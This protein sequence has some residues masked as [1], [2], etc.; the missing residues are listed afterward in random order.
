[1]SMWVGGTEKNI[2]E[3]F[4]QVEADGAILLIDEI[5]G[6]LQDRREARHSWEITGVNEMLTQIESFPGI[7]IASTNLR[8]NLD[9]AALRRFDMKI[10][11][12]Y[13][14]PHQS[15]ALLESYCD[16]L[17][18]EPPDTA[19][20]ARLGR[21]HNLTPGDFAAVTRRHRFKPVGTATDMVC[22]L[23]EECSLK[24]NFKRPIGFC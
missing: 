18:L 19:L 21:L 1:M 2:A 6:F 5:E 16:T 20:T 10:K 4:R 24:E 7:F 11:F 17:N 23:E 12:D 22:A 14:L 3:C 8:D 13:L 15:R 9:Q